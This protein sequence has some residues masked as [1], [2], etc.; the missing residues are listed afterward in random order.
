MTIQQPKQPSVPVK[1]PRV[2][3]K[4]PQARQS[5]PGRKLLWSLML[6]L[7]TLI[8]ATVTEPQPVVAQSANQSQTQ[9]SD[10]GDILLVPVSGV[11]GIVVLLGF[12]LWVYKLVYVITPNN[13]AFVRTGG[14]FAKQQLVILNGG[15]I[16]LPGFHELTRV[17]LREISIDVERTDNLAVR[18][19]DYL[20]ANMR[21]TFYV[22]ISPNAEDVKTAAAR[23]SE[24]GVISELDIKN[25]LEKRADDAIRAA[26]KRKSL[27]EVDSDK[28]GFAD[29]VLNLIQ[30]DLKKVGLTLNNIAISEIEESNTYDENNF[31]DSQGVRLRTETIQR[32][33]QQKKEV[34]L[35]TRNL[36]EQQELDA[37]KRSLA[38]S[39][40]GEESRLAHEQELETLALNKQEAIETLRAQKE[41]EA[42]EARDREAALIERN[43]ILQAQAVET[44]TIQKEL[45]LQQRQITANITL[46]EERKKLQV[47]QSLQQQ[48][49]EL[50]AITRQRTVEASRLLAQIEIAQAE[51][52]SR[53]A[54]EDVALAIANK[55]RERLAIEAERIKAEGAVQ[56]AK[57]VEAAERN[58]RIVAIEAEQ[59]A[60]RQRIAEQNVVEIEAFRRRRQAEVARQAT[61]L[62]AESIQTLADANRYRELA[63]AEGKQAIFAAENTLN[64]ANRTAKLIEALLP[65]VIDHLPEIMAALAPQ[66][67]ILG[68][69]RV[70]AVGNGSDRLGDINKLMLSTSGLALLESLL[71][72]GK[73]SSLVGQVG[74]LLR[75]GTADAAA[76]KSDNTP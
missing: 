62:E 76:A 33:I 14:V 70:Y 10:L 11:V 45:T 16:V 4:H 58:Q 6:A 47:A 36:M 37:E 29:E 9:R 44:E 50:A 51:Q 23:L 25:A 39:Q 40:Q 22:C 53:L 72:E 46:E 57:V 41:R 60:Q 20:R 49:A 7:A 38:I 54:Q 15:C 55:E 66:P 19:Q 24:G 42:Q 13:E 35:S 59:E 2:P 65:S 67:G 61:E 64:D 74:Q 73:L 1:Q 27:A 30:Q 8:P 32:A 71:E 68:D 21:V 75:S 69:A 12:S 63:E 5:K 43:K 18:T 56:T 31:F 28:L 3:V 17:P 48:E 26:A 34:E 52:Q